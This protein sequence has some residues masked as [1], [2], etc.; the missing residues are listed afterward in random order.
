MSLAGGGGGDDEERRRGRRRRRPRAGAAAAGCTFREF[1]SEGRE[2]TSDPVNN[3][4][5]NPPT[6]GSHNPLAAQDGIYAPG[7]EPNKENWVHALE[8]GRILFQYKAG[9]PQATTSAGSPRWPRRSSRA[10]AGYH[11]LVLQNNTEM[12]RPFAAVAWTR[13]LTCPRLDDAAVQAMRSFRTAYT[14]KAPEFIP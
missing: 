4:S 12:A 7:N 10:S 5:T 8:H 11:T 2:H 6:S 1:R 14:D 3:Y 13:S 9:T